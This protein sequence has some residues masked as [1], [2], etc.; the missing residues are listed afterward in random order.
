MQANSVGS[1]RVICDW[2]VRA[3]ANPRKQ[4]VDDCDLCKLQ[5]AMAELRQL[6]GMLIRRLPAEEDWSTGS[7]AH[8]QRAHTNLVCSDGNFDL[9]T[10][11]VNEE[12]CR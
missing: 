5:G 9:P 3:R 10:Q 12:W 7:P 1:A 11:T 2:K 6:V 4:L 8:A